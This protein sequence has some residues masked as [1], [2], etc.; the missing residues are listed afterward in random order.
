MSSPSAPRLPRRVHDAL[1]A[2]GHPWEMVR[3][4]KHWHIYIGGRL[5]TVV[6]GSSRNMKSG[7]CR[8]GNRDGATLSAIR[9]TVRQLEG[10]T[11]GQ[12][13]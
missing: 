8:G 3:G 11:D 4:K 5:A 9:R 13:R 6:G 10:E 7:T 12:T 1:Q 2:C